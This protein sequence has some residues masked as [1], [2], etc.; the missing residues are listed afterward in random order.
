MTRKHDMLEGTSA[1]A[2]SDDSSGSNSD[3]DDANTPS[4]PADTGVMY[5]FDAARSPSQ[6]SQI[7]NAA[8][9]K[10]VEKYEERETVKLVKSEYD[11]LDAEG[12]TVVS[13]AKKE[14]GKA[15]KAPGGTSH[16]PDADEDYEFL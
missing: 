14:K 9:A 4:P 13:P 6:G 11:V 7:L 2:L 10:A 5:S 15:R 16:V 3:F 1:A 8:L 12:E